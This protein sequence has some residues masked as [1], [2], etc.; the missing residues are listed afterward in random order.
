MRRNL[1][2]GDVLGSSCPNT[3]EKAAERWCY[4]KSEYNRKQDIRA[5][6]KG[7]GAA[8]IVGAML[9]GMLAIGIAALYI[10]L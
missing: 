6:K 9:L 4:L 3:Y 7:I 8:L 2:F 10:E 1:N 5:W